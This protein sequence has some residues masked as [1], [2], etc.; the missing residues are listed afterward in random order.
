MKNKGRKA[1]KIYN[2]TSGVKNRQP[3]I[4]IQLD[5]LIPGLEASSRNK[6]SSI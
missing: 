3:K 5:N 1:N 4:R 2:Q 6:F